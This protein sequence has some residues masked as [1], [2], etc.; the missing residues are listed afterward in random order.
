MTSIARKLRNAALALAFVFLGSLIAAKLEDVTALRLDGPF[1]AI[2]GD[3]LALG[4]DRLRLAG[5]D[6][7]EARQTC[8]DA[9]GRDWRCGERSR[10]ELERLTSAASVVCSGSSRDRYERLL[11]HCRDGGLDINAE[12][13]RLGFAVASGDYAAEERHARDEGI[14]LWSGAFER[15]RDWRVRHGMMDD[16]S[17]AAGLLAWLRDLFGR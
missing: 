16:P 6:A 12:M 17:A 9:D 2:D 5:F 14:G 4:A 3:T 1:V 7:P 8:Q 13:V 15:P 11:V 10:A